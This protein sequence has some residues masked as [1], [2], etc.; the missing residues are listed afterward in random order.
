[1][2]SSNN[3]ARSLEGEQVKYIHEFFCWLKIQWSYV[4]LLWTQKTSGYD[5]REGY[6]VIVLNTGPSTTL[7]INNYETSVKLLV[8]D[9]SYTNVKELTVYVTMSD[10]T[11]HKFECTS[12]AKVYAL[13]RE[14]VAQVFKRLFG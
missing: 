2:L 9:I 13:E 10:D 12:K 7:L 4:E 1:M 14:I 3:P 11:T 8:S 6:W 5:W